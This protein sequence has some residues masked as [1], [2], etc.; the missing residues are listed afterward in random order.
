MEREWIQAHCWHDEQIL[1]PLPKQR[2]HRGLRSGF[3]T[4][5]NHFKFYTIPNT[6]QR[7][8]C[9]EPRQGKVKVDDKPTRLKQFTTTIIDLKIQIPISK[10][11]SPMIQ[12]FW[13][14][15]YCLRAVL[16][17]LNFELVGMCIL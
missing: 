17:V 8:V 16:L 7:Q 1:C 11:A 6:F 3:V 14:L 2:S 4:I 12:I 10:F 13:W 9:M 5:S 15:I